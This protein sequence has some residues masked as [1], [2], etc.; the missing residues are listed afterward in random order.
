MRLTIVTPTFNVAAYI[1]R[2]VRSVVSQGVEDLEYILVDGVSTD[3]T[4]EKLEP[5]GQRFVYRK[6]KSGALKNQVQHFWEIMLHGKKL[7]AVEY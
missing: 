1:E 4:L 2:S 6:Y 5:F 7:R 3:G